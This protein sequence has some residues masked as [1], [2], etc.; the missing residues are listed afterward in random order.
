MSA[1][2]LNG[3][4]IRRLRNCFKT[5][6]LPG[7]WSR[8]RVFFSGAAGSQSRGAEVRFGLNRGASHSGNQFSRLWVPPH[9]CRR[10]WVGDSRA[11]PGARGYRKDRVAEVERA[12]G[13]TAAK[14]GRLLI[15]EDALRAAVKA[16]TGNV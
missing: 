1:P 16:A 12:V 11:W 6:R 5:H 7:A 9:H 13:G 10:R 2:N 4:Y 3:Q 8:V 14:R 15:V